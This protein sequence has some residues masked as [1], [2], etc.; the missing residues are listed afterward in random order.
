[1]DQHTSPGPG[2]SEFL[3]LRQASNQLAMSDSWLRK[4]LRSGT[5]PEAVRFGNRLR[6]SRAS[7][8]KFAQARTERAK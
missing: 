7:L 5:A 2:Q 1:M 4:A 8:A 6:F 3:T